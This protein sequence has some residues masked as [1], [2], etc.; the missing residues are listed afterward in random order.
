M[1]NRNRLRVGISRFLISSLLIVFLVC[2]N[3][4]VVFAEG[5]VNIDYGENETIELPI[6]VT[7]WQS[8]A[9]KQLEMIN[10]FRAESNVSYWNQ[11]NETKTTY[12]VPGDSQSQL[13]SITYD[14]DLEKVAMKRAFES[15]VLWDHMR[16]NGTKWSTIHEEFGYPIV[17]RSENLAAGQRNSTSVFSSWRED[18]AYYSGQG[19]RR[20]M[21]NPNFK[22]VGCACVKYHNKYFWVQEFSGRVSSNVETSAKDDICIEKVTLNTKYIDSWERG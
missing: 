2:S 15:A 19:H 6:E 4:L 21:L 10:S 14:Y 1:M 13:G 16:P 12:N 17:I 9:R 5:E 11:D 18:S 22:A 20:N 7:Y 8:E 3:F